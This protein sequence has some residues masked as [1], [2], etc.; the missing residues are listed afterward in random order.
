MQV[1]EHQALSFVSHLQKE[2]RYSKNTIEAYKFELS[3]FSDKI[4]KDFLRVSTSDI[5]DFIL[6]VNAK[7]RIVFV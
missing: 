6:F 4:N 3:R 5:K 1:N 7:M 2:R